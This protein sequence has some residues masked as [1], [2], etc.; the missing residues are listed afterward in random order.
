MNYKKTIAAFLCFALSMS[1]SANSDI[2]I[3]PLPKSITAS[4][5]SLTLPANFSIGGDA[6]PDSIMAEATNFA[7]IYHQV[8]GQNPSVSASNSDALLK[9]EYSNAIAPEGYQLTVT[10]TGAT[11]KASTTAGFFYAF[12]TI[13]QLLPAEFMAGVKSSATTFSLPCVT[14]ND[15]PRFSYRGFMLDEGRHFF[16]MNEV[17]KLI[18]L[19]AVYKMNNFH[20]HLTEDQGWRIEIKKYPRL[21]S[22]GSIA[23]N[24]WFT[25]MKR[26]GYWTNSTYGPYFYTQD[27]I[28][29]V[30]AYAKER[31]INIIPEIDMPGHFTAAMAAY[32]EFSCTPY[33]SHSVWP[34]G[35]ISTDVMNVAN[36]KAIQ[37]AKDILKEVCD[38]F[39]GPY[40]HIGGDECPD[41]AWQGNE[42]CR[43]LYQAEML[44]SYRQLQSRF[45]KQMA[46]YLR[47]M[48]RTTVVWNEAITA[49]GADLQ[50]IKDAGV[51]VF[52]WNP[53][54]QSA[55]KAAQNGLDNVVTFYGPYYINRKQSTE[56]D[57]PSGAGD[58]SDSLRTTY[59]AI[60]VPSTVAASLV[61]YYKGVQGTFWTEHVND[62]VYLEYLALPRLMAV[63]EA[64]WTQ[65]NQ[66]NYVNFRQRVAADTTFLNLAGFNY[67][68]RDLVAKKRNIVYPERDTYYRIV[69]RATDTDRK[70]TCI[71]LLYKDSPVMTLRKS[72]NPQVNRLW[73][74]S[75]LDKA[76]SAYKYQMWKFER[77][78]TDTTLF[79]LVCQ[80]FPEGSVKASPTEVS[81]RGRWDYDLTTKHYNFKL[82]TAGYGT[83]GSNHFYTINSSQTNGWYINASMGGQGFSVNLWT[84]PSDGNGGLWTFVAGENNPVV[85][86]SF[87]YLNT[88][89][90]IQIENA[91]EGFSH[92]S[93]ADNGTAKYLQWTDKGGEPGSPCNIWQVK[94]AQTNADNSQ[95]LQLQNVATHRYMGSTTNGDI[96][97]IGRPVQMAASGSTNLRLTYSKASG[98]FTLSIGA[99]NLFPIPMKSDAHPGVVSSG[100]PILPQGNAWSVR[101]VNPVTVHL[102][103]EAG[104]SLGTSLTDK[105]EA[106]FTA[107]VLPN[108]TV[109]NTTWENSASVNVTYKRLSHTVRLECRDGNGGIIA[110]SDTTVSVGNKLNV[111]TPAFNFYTLE[112]GFG[113]DLDVQSDTTFTATFTTTALSGIKKPAEPALTLISG[114]SYAIYDSSPTDLNRRG[115]RNV[116]PNGKV[117]QTRHIADSEPGLVWQ[118]TA[119]GNAFSVKNLYTGKYIPQL[120][121]SQPVTLSNTP[122]SFTFTHDKD[123]VAWMVKG[124]NNLYW[125]GL[126]D[127]MTGWNVY[128]HPYIL[129]DYIVEPYFTVTVNCKNEGGQVLSSNT[130]FV[131]A[132]Q[133]F[134]LVAPAISGYALRKTE[135]EE[136]LDAVSDFVTV[137]LT[138]TGS[139]TGIAGIAA[140][141]TPGKGIYNLQG[142]KLSKPQ[143]GINIINGR[144]VV[145]L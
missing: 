23:P 34:S 53:A 116:D 36:P 58:G 69:T 64:G 99:R 81:N 124:R 98:E 136:L 78:A 25:D 114:R 123:G 15:A 104:K 96:D 22:V 83:D 47:T 73:A 143:R 4:N 109:T 12:Q 141:T 24:S 67:C 91:V 3:I 70:N 27:Q 140:D 48:N 35:G 133:P 38:L 76:D 30:V 129:Y 72:N 14:I 6:L 85:Y 65:E 103:D 95:T 93:L 51:K 142:I 100:S 106:S 88:G 105:D 49:G 112:Q 119:N 59:N 75:Q 125:D 122:E 29:E 46:D 33:G 126:V 110:F 17:K 8:T 32:P 45:I 13:R 132:G 128:G 10:T 115:F 86:D 82:G 50:S 61:P 11:I 134:Q 144:K 145:V 87:E 60:P 55:L 80:A 79:A 9:L 117:H 89:D 28:R 92:Q 52:C 94:A 42:E 56:P 137:N 40:I 31:H 121:S 111:E 102:T 20:W 7:N 19:M 18:D 139:A 113:S 131:R 84:A 68:R 135:G 21:T 71:T 130:S 101:K 16:G 37:F 43:K 127:G 107:P 2:G 63:A 77:S 39:P 62:S 54:S 57:E 5:A 90:Y 97:K 26:G 41:N 108:F 66:K 138:Y 74:A 44:T 118:L 120:V 1:V